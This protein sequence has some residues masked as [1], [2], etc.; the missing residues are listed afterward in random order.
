MKRWIGFMF[1]IAFVVILS[2]CG[3]NNDKQKEN[4]NSDGD[5]AES[6]T[7]D[8]ADVPE[9]GDE[10]KGNIA[11]SL[12]NVDGKVVGIATL[13]EDESGVHV[14]LE[15][16][17]L[18][19]GT[20]ALHIHEKGACEAPDF[21]SAG[22]HYNPAG[23]NH[24]KEDPNGPHAGDFDNIEVGEDGTVTKEFTTDK[25]TLEKGKENTLFT[26]DGTSLVIHA[27]AD[28]YKSQPSGDAGDRIA[29]G[30]ID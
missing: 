24:G 10:D 28:D 19:E 27:E 3:G 23:N 2:A 4:Q 22:G 17:E 29:C 6:E 18:P 21:E 26:D 9:E 7:E 20:H 25:V 15:G 14:K 16:K 13:T 12:N 30:V 1:V 11:V 8:A 5:E